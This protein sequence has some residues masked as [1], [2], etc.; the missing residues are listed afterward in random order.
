MNIET[1]RLNIVALTPEQLELLVNCTSELER[2]LKCV[3]QAEK[4]EGT[5]KNI[6]SGQIKKTKDEGINYLW[7]TFWLMIRK[8]DG[9]VVGTID[10]KDVPNDNGEVEIG[11]GL[12]KDHEHHGYMTEAVFAM[13]NWARKKGNVNRIIAETELNNSASENVL[14]RCGF[15][16]HFSGVTTWWRL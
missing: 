8:K 16:K 9:I 10:F 15:V 14:R 12:G 5:F 13:C 2:E 3:Y 4:I 7:H 1:E 6:L 11:Y